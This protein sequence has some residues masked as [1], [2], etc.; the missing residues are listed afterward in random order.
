MSLKTEMLDDSF[1]H[2]LIQ[3]V[4]PAMSGMFL[5]LPSM[6]Y[7]QFAMQILAKTE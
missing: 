5:F 6:L 3:E 4:P 7:N 2:L 1:N